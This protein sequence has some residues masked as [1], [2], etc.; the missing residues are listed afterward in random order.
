M[1]A[2][3]PHAGVSGKKKE[4]IGNGVDHAVRN[5]DATALLGD[6]IPDIVQLDFGLWCKTVSHL[7]GRGLL[8]GE[9]DA[10]ALLD[11]LSQRTHRLLR[12]HAPFATCKRSFRRIN[13]CQNFR[14][15][16]LAFLPQRQGFLDR[17]FFTLK[18]AILDGLADKRLLV[19]GEMNFHHFPS[20][21]LANPCVNVPVAM[22]AK[23]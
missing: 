20:I 19:G 8:G 9:V 7:A 13:R 6:V 3:T 1:I 21:G 5:L 12:N 17:I 22:A 23:V 18:A 2:A 10:S 16:A 4:A 14:S 11:F 15:N